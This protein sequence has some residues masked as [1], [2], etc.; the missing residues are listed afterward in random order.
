MLS[1]VP[2]L[3]E[4]N[5][6]V[7]L[8]SSRERADGIVETASIVSP[9]PK[10]HRFY[11]A[12]NSISLDLFAVVFLSRHKINHPKNTSTSYA[13]WFVSTTGRHFSFNDF[14]GARWRRPHIHASRT[15]GNP[16]KNGAGMRWKLIKFIS[17]RRLDIQRWNAADGRQS[18]AL[19]W[20]LSWWWL[21]SFVIL[22][23]AINQYMSHPLPSRKSTQ[24]STQLCVYL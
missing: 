13:T 23:L 5:V 14:S 11:V 17:Q 24:T 20:Q 8:I 21:A 15:F 18:N 7:W 6:L 22:L 16:Q 2:R 9:R 10:W 19:N 1:L 3:W 4:N 12:D